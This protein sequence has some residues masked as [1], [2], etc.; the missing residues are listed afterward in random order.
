MGGGGVGGVE[1]VVQ[2]INLF[3]LC[4][5]RNLFFSLLSLLFFSSFF[6]LQLLNTFFQLILWIQIFYLI[7]LCIIENRYHAQKFPWRC[8]FKN[9]LTQA[10]VFEFIGLKF[11]LTPLFQNT[12]TVLESFFLTQQ[13]FTGSRSRKRCEIC[14]K[15]TIKT[16][17]RRQIFR[18]IEV[19]LE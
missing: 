6:K 15:L 2:Y 10:V 19:F 9:T 14:S 4:A 18:I 11:F 5:L 1:G 13:T 17:E 7:L 16:P 12:G 8:F 3:S